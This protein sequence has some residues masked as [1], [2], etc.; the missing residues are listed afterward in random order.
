MKKAL[1]IFGFAFLALN[2]Q[3]QTPKVDTVYKAIQIQPLVANAIKKDTAYQMIWMV[4]NVHR[5]D[6]LPAVAYPRFFNRKGQQVM[7]DEII[8]PASVLAVWLSNTVIDDYI[9]S[10]YGLVKRK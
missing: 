2:A 10:Y 3:S 6:S 4:N 9:L 8:I 5:N 7:Q 1:L